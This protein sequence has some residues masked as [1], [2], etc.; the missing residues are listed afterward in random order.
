MKTR[1]LLLNTF[2]FAGIAASVN[3]QIATLDFTNSS[4]SGTFEANNQDPYTYVN[5]DLFGDGTVTVDLTVD[6]SSGGSI[7]QR[8]QGLGSNNGNSGRFDDGETMTF[9]F[10]NLG[11]TDFASVTGFTFVGFVAEVQDSAYTI[12]SEDII[13]V[14]SVSLSA[15]DEADSTGLVSDLNWVGNAAAQEGYDLEDGFTGDTSG[16][17]ISTSG[18]FTIAAFANA[19]ATG[20]L[21]NY[22]SMRIAGFQIDVV[23]EP[24]SY[25]LIAGCLALASVM[26]R[27]RKA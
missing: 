25:A 4:A 17:T 18:T 24:S 7:D 15:R 22:D 14:N 8:E 1:T 9:T 12:T 19:A 21:N 27:R 11:G 16:L 6:V 20:G 2:L 13:T 23:P 10:S 26:V 3:A 5:L